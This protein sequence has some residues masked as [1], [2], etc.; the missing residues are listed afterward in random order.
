MDEAENC[1]GGVRSTCVHTP[2]ARCLARQPAQMCVPFLSPVIVRPDYR[3]NL[4]LMALQKACQQ[5]S[6]RASVPQ[7]NGFQWA[8]SNSPPR[9]ERHSSESML[10]WVVLMPFSPTTQRCMSSISLMH[11]QSGSRATFPGLAPILSITIY[12]LRCLT[13]YSAR[14]LCNAAERMEKW[15]NLLK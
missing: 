9:C 7:H 11:V 1:N 5:I 6:H 3:G 4:A 2:E 8:H 12:V 13:V 15:K 10:L 14:L